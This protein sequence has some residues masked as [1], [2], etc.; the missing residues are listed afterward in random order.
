MQGEEEE[1]EEEK[2]EAA[3]EEEERNSCGFDREDVSTPKQQRDKH[4]GFT[5]N[6]IMFD[7]DAFRRRGMLCSTECLVWEKRL[8]PTH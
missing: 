6:R 2:E 3:E 4:T 8:T 1:E 7:C 5:K